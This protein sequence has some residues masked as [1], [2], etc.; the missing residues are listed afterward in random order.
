MDSSS[1]RFLK[2]CLTVREAKESLVNKK[3]GQPFRHRHFQMGD[4]VHARQL[5]PPPRLVHDP[6][7][8]G[9]QWLSHHRGRRSQMRDNNDAEDE[10]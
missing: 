7:G 3:R 2:D 5:H 9:G 4:P 8:I 10:T 1:P 6:P